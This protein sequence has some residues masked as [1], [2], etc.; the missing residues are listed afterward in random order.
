MY[1]TFKK[2][3][4]CDVSI[5]TN[6]PVS[7]SPEVRQST[8]N[9]TVSWLDFTLLLIQAIK[10]GGIKSTTTVTDLVYTT[11]RAANTPVRRKRRRTPHITAR[12]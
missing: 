10:G 4:T 6:E 9:R 7:V 1:E 8:I 11:R 3:C 2:V 12:H 5:G